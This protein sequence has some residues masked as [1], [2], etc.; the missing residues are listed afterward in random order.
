M[1]KGLF[2]TFAPG[3]MGREDIFDHGSKQRRVALKQLSR[4][5]RIKSCN[6]ELISPLM[7][8]RVVPPRM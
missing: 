6:E 2:S 7:C 8:E 4:D 1:R 5:S 3:F